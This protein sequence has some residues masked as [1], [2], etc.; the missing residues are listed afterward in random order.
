MVLFYISAYIEQ[1][2]MVDKWIDRY[3]DNAEWPWVATF[4]LCLTGDDKI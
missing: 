3:L 2:C 4:V 1:K